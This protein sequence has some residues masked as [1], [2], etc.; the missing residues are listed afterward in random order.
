MRTI[1]EHY[2]TAILAVLSALAILIWIG[3]IVNRK[4]TLHPLFKEGLA[5]DYIDNSSESDEDLSLTAMQETS[6]K[7]LPDIHVQGDLVIDHPYESGEIIR[8]RRG[9]PPSFG[10]RFLKIWNFQGVDLSKQCIQSDGRILFSAAGVYRARV[11]LSEK[12]GRSGA[13]E[14]YLG[15]TA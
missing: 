14:V 7:S 12:D 2:G 15:V 11:F 6:G 9:Y 8:T 5:G 4:G 13:V 1:L 3:A 10:V